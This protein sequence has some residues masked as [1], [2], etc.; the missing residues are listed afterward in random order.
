LALI[1]PIHP[2]Q[3]GIWSVP[4]S[5]PVDTAVIGRRTI[6]YYALDKAGNFTVAER[7]VIV[8]EDKL[9]P[10]IALLGDKIIKQ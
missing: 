8:E 10:V 3:D 5:P 1:N 4:A 2:E 7:V 9:K 6:R